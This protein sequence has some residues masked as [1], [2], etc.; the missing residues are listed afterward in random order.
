MSLSGLEKNT[1]TIVSVGFTLGLGLIMLGKFTE[2][3]GVTVA[4][5]T[6][7]GKIIVGLGEMAD[8]I[9]II[10]LIIVFAV[11]YKKMKQ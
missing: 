5:N 7:L 10:V 1:K 3:S 11:L 6:A 9:G 2:T 8:W 4:A